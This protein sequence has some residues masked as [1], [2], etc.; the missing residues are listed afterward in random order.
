MFKWFKYII[1]HTNKSEHLFNTQR[2]LSPCWQ[3]RLNLSPKEWIWSRIIDLVNLGAEACQTWSFWRHF[4]M[5][6]NLQLEQKVRSR[7]SLS[8]PFWPRLSRYRW[9][10][11]LRKCKNRYLSLLSLSNNFER[12]DRSANGHQSNARFDWFETGKVW[13]ASFRSRA[14]LN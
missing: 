14:P 6:V 10:D 13:Y 12:L 9:T 8:Q 7:S 1:F 5:T 3:I 11:H 2:Y 4:S